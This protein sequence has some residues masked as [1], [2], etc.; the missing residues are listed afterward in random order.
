[1]LPT[2]T[3]TVSSSHPTELAGNLSSSVIIDLHVSTGGEGRAHMK[4]GQV[5]NLSR[6]QPDL[7]M[8]R[9]ALRRQR[10]GVS[11]EG[12]FFSA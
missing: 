8:S 12:V 3:Q 4:Q 5:R 2:V 9:K 6:N 11:V 1:M 10:T 7:P